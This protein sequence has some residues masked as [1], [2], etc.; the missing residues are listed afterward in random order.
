MKS[1]YKKLWQQVVDEEHVKFHK[2]SVWEVVRAEDVPDNAYVFT[3]TWAMKHKANG[4]FRT[5]LN[6]REY[7]QV[8][9]L[10][11]DGDNTSAPVICIMMDC[12][13]MTLAIMVD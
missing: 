3:T 6:A 7:K 13:V 2:Y 9:G 5:W 4:T 8:D 11:F 10:Q 12:L 1:D